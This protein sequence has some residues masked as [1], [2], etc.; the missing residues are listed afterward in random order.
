MYLY[1]GATEFITLKH[2]LPAPEDQHYTD[3]SSHPDPC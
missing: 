3:L 1:D 2:A